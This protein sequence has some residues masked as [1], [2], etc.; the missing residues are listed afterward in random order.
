M[1]SADRVELHTLPSEPA[2]QAWCR[3]LQRHG[4]D[5]SRVILPGWIERQPERYR[6]AYLAL[7]LDR[8]RRPQLDATGRR[9]LVEPEFVQLE[10]PPL[11]WPEL[12]PSPT[13]GEFD[14]G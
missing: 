2:R 13:E 12:P 6:L 8:H 5:P 4:V 7:V 11:P 14:H 9:L 3:W 1:P 10:G